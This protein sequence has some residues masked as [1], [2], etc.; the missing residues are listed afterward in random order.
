M[1]WA[2][3]WLRIT[4]RP[5]RFSGPTSTWTHWYV[6]CYNRVN[7]HYLI[8]HKCEK[9]LGFLVGCRAPQEW[10]EICFRSDEEFQIS[11]VKRCEAFA[12]CRPGK[13]DFN[14]VPAPF[15]KRQIH[16]IS[17]TCISQYLAVTT[18]V[19]RST[20]RRQC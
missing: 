16:F 13:L 4:E 9:R 7:T 19:S 6:I 5:S 18:I 20:F 3:L 10:E 2:G 1:F 12:V 14:S 15:V 11:L 8:A 17:K